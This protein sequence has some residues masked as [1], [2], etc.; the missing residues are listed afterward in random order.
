ML[1]IL[2]QNHFA[3]IDESDVLSSSLIAD[4]EVLKAL[5]SRKFGWSYF[6]NELVYDAS[7]GSFKPAFD[8]D[9]EAPVIVELGD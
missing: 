9:E 1:I 3:N 8:D 5:V 4:V 6:S 7:L 2:V